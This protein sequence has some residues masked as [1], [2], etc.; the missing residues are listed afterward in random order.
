MLDIDT[1]YDRVI[2]MNLRCD[3]QEG[4]LQVVN[5]A[6]FD[7]HDHGNREGRKDL[8]EEMYVEGGTYPKRALKVRVM[9]GLPY[10][11]M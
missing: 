1:Y 5:D 6:F 10:N 8:R 2:A 4:V 3:I 9:D 7:A 11:L